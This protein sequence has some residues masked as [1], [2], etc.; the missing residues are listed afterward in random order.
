WYRLL[1]LLLVVPG[2][3]VLD[4]L[5]KSAFHRTRPI[6]EHPLVV[7]KSYSFP[8]GHTMGAT[9]LYGLAAVFVYHRLTAWRGKVWLVATA[10]SIVFLVGLSRVA[11]GAH[12][13]SDVLG[14]A[15]AGLAWLALCVTAVETLR[16]RRLTKSGIPPPSPSVATGTTVKVRAHD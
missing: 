3:A 4:V 2:G 15:A 12:F 11:L 13:L 10:S 1:I 16:R 5:L 7:L 14:G 6:L 8:S 9:L